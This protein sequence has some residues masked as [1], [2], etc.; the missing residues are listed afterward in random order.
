METR[1]AIVLNGG[2]ARASYQAGALRALYEIIKK[3]QNLFE[4]ITGN[5][6]GAIN[7]AYMASNAEDWGASTQS[8]LDLWKR[9]KPED[10]YDLSHYTMTKLGTKWMKGTFLRTEDG[11]DSINGLL[12]T[13]PLRKTIER[14]MDFKKIKEHFALGNLNG[15]SL[16]T[17]NYYSGASVIFFDGTDVVEE[18]SKPDKIIMR[19]EIKAEHV[20]ASSAIPLFF[21]PVKINGSYFGDGCIRQITPLSPAIDLGAKKII[22]ISIRHQQTVEGMVEKTLKRNPV[23][24]LSQV[25]GVMMNSIFLDSLDADYERLSKINTI[26]ELMGPKSPWR[27]IPILMLKP[28]R[29]LG[30]MTEKLNKELPT[31]LRYFLR[32]IGVTGQSGL[33]LLSY[34][35]F[36]SSYTEQIAELGYEDTLKQKKRVLNF[37]DG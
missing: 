27:Y 36:D 19:T 2:G 13:D 23:P 25:A 32:T 12:N 31:M 17:T 11:K 7:A 4:I 16:S 8:L 37:I 21:S 14:E 34:L 6:A 18:R 5:S 22:A 30:V 10:V 1:N 20:M 33:D 29:D 24:Q 15:L 9:I 3:D 28:S 35:A 26:V